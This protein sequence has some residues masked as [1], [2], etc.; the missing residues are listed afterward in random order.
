MYVISLLQGMVFYGPIA[1]LYRAAQGVSVFQITLIESISLVLC[2]LLEIPWGIAA[3]RIGYRRTMIV[4]CGLYFLSKLVFWQ[5][6]NF[7]WF[8]LER[9]MLSVVIAGMSGV[10]S[11]I[12][13][14]SCEKEDSQKV[15]GIYN[16]L[17]TAGLLLAAVIFSSLL[18]SHYKLAGGLTAVSYGLSF[19]ASLFL[20]EVRPKKPRGF[21]ADGFRAVLR[22]RFSDKSLW[23]F[24]LAVAFLSETHQT[25]TVFL[26]QVQYQTCGMTPSAIG[27]V[28][29]GVTLAGLCGVWSAAAAKKTGIRAACLLFSVL[30]AAA[31]SLLAFTGSAA[32][33]VGGILVLRVSNSLFQPFQLDW[34]NRQI[35]TSDR[36]TALSV[37]AML[38][39][40]VGAGTN[41]AFGF[42]AQRSLPSAFLFGAGLCMAGTVLLFFWLRRKKTS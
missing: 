23:L 1:A 9:V 14:L 24:L 21:D 13:Y 40:S 7:W 30:P 37:N 15:F 38:V 32:L 42:L 5:A 4:C 34:Q 36:A 22:E 39:D 26:N 8:L 6:A 25:I 17:G 20:R 16:S 33:S 10:D 2:L 19:L 12:L 31:C 29:V 41:L 28:Y 3:D 18:G 27:Y 11:A 35:Q